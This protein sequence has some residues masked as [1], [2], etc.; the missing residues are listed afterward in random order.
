MLL[1][2]PWTIRS[3]IIPHLVLSVS[4]DYYFFSLMTH[5]SLLIVQ[6]Y[7]T[8]AHPLSSQL[9]LHPLSLLD[10]LFL[11]TSSFFY[12]VFLLSLCLLHPSLQAGPR[13]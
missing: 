4:L 5:S 7:H 6:C 3:V 9:L 8:V 12:S 11:L 10:D 13:H 1:A 2:L